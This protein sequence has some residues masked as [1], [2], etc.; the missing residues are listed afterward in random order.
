MSLV[1][2]SIK[3]NQV[4]H[5]PRIAAHVLENYS[6]VNPNSNYSLAPTTD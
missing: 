1:I 2:K 4:I 3:F 6:L 5:V